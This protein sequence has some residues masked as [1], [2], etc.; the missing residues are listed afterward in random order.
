MT[1]P[2][3]TAPDANTRLGLY[4]CLYLERWGTLPTQLAEWLEHPDHQEDAQS[5]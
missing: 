5:A 1:S 3:V 2:Q 4:L